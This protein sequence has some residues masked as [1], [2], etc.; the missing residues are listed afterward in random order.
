MSCGASGDPMEKKKED[1]KE[2]FA[3]YS[4][5][6][7]G[8]FTVGSIATVIVGAI[9][10]YFVYRVFASESPKF[11]GKLRSGYT[12]T[13]TKLTTNPF[14]GNKVAPT[15]NTVMVGGRHR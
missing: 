9:L 11:S 14:R 10:V 5:M 12:N 15:S 3:D 6:K 13:K 7:I 1:K 4:A 2:M 8:G